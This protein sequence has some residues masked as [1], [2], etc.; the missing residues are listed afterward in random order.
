VA[1]ARGDPDELI[2]V[3]GDNPRSPDDYLEIA[4]MLESDGRLDE[5]VEWSELSQMASGSVQ[6]RPG[7]LAK[8]RSVVM[9]SHPDSIAMAAR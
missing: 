2:S 6:D 7:N 1:I 3:R 9:N 4:R 8:S 5:A